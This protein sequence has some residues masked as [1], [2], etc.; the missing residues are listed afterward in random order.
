MSA[1]ALKE[2]E[3]P[4]V[5]QWLKKAVRGRRA[6]RHQGGATRTLN[7]SFLPTVAIRRAAASHSRNADTFRERSSCEGNTRCWSV[8]A[9]LPK[10]LAARR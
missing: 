4:P 6:L 3:A 1:S 10:H 8:L 7:S 9:Q 5:K 2:S